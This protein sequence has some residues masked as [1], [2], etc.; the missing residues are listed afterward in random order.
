MC[1]INQDHIM[2]GSWD[3]NFCHF[4][5]FLPFYPLTTQKIKIYKK[6]TNNFTKIYDICY[7]VPETWRVILLWTIFHP[8]IPLTVS[9]MKIKKKKKKAP[10]DIIILHNCTKNRDHMLYCP[11]DMARDG[12]N[13]YFSSWA[14]F[15]LLPLQQHKK[16]KFQKMKKTHGDIIIFTQVY[17]KSSS[18]ALLFLRYGAW[19]M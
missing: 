4:C 6:K 1:T 3:I 8:F 9:K 13:C 2:Y 14:V 7:T 16:W 12:C 5:P 11:W 15:A 18:Y 17:Q 19:H 10:G